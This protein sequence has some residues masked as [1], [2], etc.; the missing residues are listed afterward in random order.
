MTPQEILYSVSPLKALPLQLLQEIWSAAT[1][2]EL[3]QDDIVFTDGDASDGSLYMVAE[4][5]LAVIINRPDGTIETRPKVRGDLCGESALVNRDH[6]RTATVQV[7]SSSA[8][9]LRW[10]GNALLERHSMQPLTKLLG[11]IAWVNT[12]ETQ[13]L[14]QF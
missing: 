5:E 9:L 4:G 8:V 2:V 7:I 12:R 14:K 10:D 11:S 13:D 6:S 3:A 1:Q